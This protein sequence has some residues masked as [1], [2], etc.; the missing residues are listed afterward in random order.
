MSHNTRT[1]NLAIPEGLP[2][3]R[4]DVARFWSKVDQGG[5]GCWSWRGATFRNGYG[6]FGVMLAG[7]QKR[8][9]TLYAHRIAWALSHGAVPGASYVMHACD[10]RRCVNP[11]HLS[12]GTQRDNMADAKAKG[13]ALGGRAHK[14]FIARTALRKAS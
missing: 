12:L 4:G 1:V 10:N 9:Q 6:M 11:S 13:V 14:R 2:L 8:Q 7:K 5:D 3:D